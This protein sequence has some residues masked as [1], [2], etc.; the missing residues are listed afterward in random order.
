MS[1][2]NWHNKA[3]RVKVPTPYLSGFMSLSTSKWNKIFVG[4]SIHNC[5]V[6]FVKQTVI[7][8]KKL[9]IEKEMNNK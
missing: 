9:I 6:G 5:A 8:L 3:N 4:C 1:L 2:F 7:S